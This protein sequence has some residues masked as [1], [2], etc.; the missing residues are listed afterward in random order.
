MGVKVESISHGKVRVTTPDKPKM[1]SKP[2]AKAPEKPAGR[3]VKQR[4]VKNNAMPA[5]WLGGRK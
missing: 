2:A 1:K 4:L 5:K 3:Q